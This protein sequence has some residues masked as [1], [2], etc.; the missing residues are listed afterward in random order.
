MKAAR[1]LR[2]QQIAVIK[3][4]LELVSEDV[5]AR[6]LL[7]GSYA[8]LGE[9]ASAVAE[10]KTAIALRPNDS[11]ILYNAACT[12]ALLDRKKDALALLKKSNEAGFL[13]RDWASQDPDL[14]C[15]YDEP[16]FKAL[17]AQNAT[18]SSRGS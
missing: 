1:K 6:I 15:L 16:E 12:Y 3:R 4:H 11:N 8:F 18:L 5:R 10:L 9:E 14:A 7:A 17:I 2:Q 13:N